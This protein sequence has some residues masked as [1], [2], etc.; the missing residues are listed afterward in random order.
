MP[1][2]FD[3]ARNKMG[4]TAQPVPPV[5]APEIAADAIVFA[6]HARRREIWV[7][8]S[9]FAAISANKAA[10]GLLDR[11]LARTGYRSRLGAEPEVPGRADNL[12][13]RRPEIPARTDGLATSR[14]NGAR[15]SGSPGTARSRCWAWPR[16][17]LA[18]RSREGAS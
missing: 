16:S 10:P 3:W 4:R 15:S 18:P 9:T 2:Q 6:A 5:F 1:A 17:F 12:S 14:S 8:G 7:G 13:R 11:Y